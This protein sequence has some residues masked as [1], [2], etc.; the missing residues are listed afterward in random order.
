M[1][2]NKEFNV[3]YANYRLLL[4]GILGVLTLLFTIIG[5]DEYMWTIENLRFIEAGYTKE[6][7]PGVPGPQWVLKK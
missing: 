3:E 1:R 6:A 7:L 2:D 5:V 4:I